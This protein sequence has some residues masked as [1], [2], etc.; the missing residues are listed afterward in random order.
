MGSGSSF[1]KS[2]RSKD[3]HQSQLT[4]EQPQSVPH[5]TT[6]TQITPVANLDSRYHL[7]LNTIND[8][9]SMVSPG[10]EF[11]LMASVPYTPVGDDINRYKYYCPICMNYFKDILKSQCCGNYA[12]LSCC[13]DYL[14]AH[15][16]IADSVNEIIGCTHLKNVPCPNCGTLGFDPRM[17]ALIDNVRDYSSNNNFGQIIMMQSS[18]IRI[19]DSFDDL[20]RKMIKYSDMV[21][22][23]AAAKRLDEEFAYGGGQGLENEEAASTIIP[24]TNDLAGPYNQGDYGELTN[25]LAVDMINDIINSTMSS[26]LIS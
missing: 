20:K 3:V 16:L 24:D 23:T 19:G 13:K 10:R 15:S 1:L 14:A 22:T 6:Q 9:K 11:A 21:S 7:D 12:C 25:R 8:M 26:R 2:R 4:E 18:P 5:S 17:V